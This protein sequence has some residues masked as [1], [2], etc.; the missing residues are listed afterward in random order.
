MTNN[1]EVGVVVLPSTGRQVR[2]RRIPPDLL[3]AFDRAHQPPRPPK[4]KAKTIGGGTE[5]V[6]DVEDPT[7]LKSMEEFGAKR[8]IDLRELIFDFVDPILP[9]DP[10]L[11]ESWERRLERY[12]IPVSDLAMLKAFYIGDPETDY[13]VIIN[14]VLRLS[15]VTNGE[16]EAALDR[17]RPEMDGRDSGDGTSVAEEQG[18]SE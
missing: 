6:D 15:T 8:G 7:Y 13:E 16:V 18:D 11:I 1:A 2:C 9:D 14:E 17:F 4:R 5:W 10:A 12:G 3:E